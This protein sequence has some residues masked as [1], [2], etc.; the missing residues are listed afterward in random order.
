MCCW[1]SGDAVSGHYHPRTWWESFGI[2]GFLTCNFCL[3]ALEGKRHTG[4]IWRTPCLCLAPLCRAAFGQGACDKLGSP[5][6][7]W[8]NPES[9]AFPRFLHSTWTWNPVSWPKQT[10]VSQWIWH[11]R[12]WFYSSP[13]VTSLVSWRYFL[14]SHNPFGCLA[15]SFGKTVLR[16]GLSQNIRILWTAQAL[17]YESFLWDVLPEGILHFSCFLF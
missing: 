7:L 16:H 6:C 5:G 12:R 4:R 10:V 9:W 17:Y 13:G 3:G 1:S 8:G 14:N 2:T 15:L 11:G